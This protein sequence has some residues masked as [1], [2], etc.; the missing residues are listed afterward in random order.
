M[1]IKSYCFIEIKRLRILSLITWFEKDKELLAIWSSQ[2]EALITAL[3]SV[4]ELMHEIPT[5]VLFSSEMLMA[6]SAKENI[7]KIK[8]FVDNLITFF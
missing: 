8:T 2:K 5:I 1:Q 4:V 6:A 7:L 3:V